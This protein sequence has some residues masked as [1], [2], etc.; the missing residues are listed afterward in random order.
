[1]SAIFAVQIKRKKKGC[2][3][4]D[5]PGNRFKKMRKNY[6]RIKADCLIHLR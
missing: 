5:N 1:M 4:K 3:E 6:K 2:L